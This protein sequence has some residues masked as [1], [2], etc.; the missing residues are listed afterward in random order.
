MTS[1]EVWTLSTEVVVEVEVV[2]V[3]EVEDIWHTAT[4]PQQPPQPQHYILLLYV[5]TTWCRI[6]RHRGAMLVRNSYGAST[7]RPTDVRV[8]DI[9]YRRSNQKV[10]Y[11]HFRRSWRLVHFRSILTIFSVF[12]GG[13]SAFGP[14]HCRGLTLFFFI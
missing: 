9:I 5:D 14:M 3:V 12:F 10:S 7:Y 13:N 6:R 4:Q 11:V 2:E 1:Y 8:S